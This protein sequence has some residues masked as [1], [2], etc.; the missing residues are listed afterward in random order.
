MCKDM[1]IHESVI[2]W[3]VRIERELH[4]NPE[5]FFTTWDCKHITTYY[6]CINALILS[7]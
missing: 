1:Y 5:Y 2:I 3:G 6:L 7:K 4:I